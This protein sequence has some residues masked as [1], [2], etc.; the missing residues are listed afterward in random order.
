MDLTDRMLDH[1]L[2]L[3]HR[4]LDAAAA[5]PDATLDEP[6]PVT[7]DAPYAFDDGAPTARSMFVRLI[8]SKEVWSAALAGRE[9]PAREG[10]SI[11]CLRRR[12]DDAG[13]EFAQ[14]VR[15]IRDRGAWDAAFVDAL[16]DPPESFTYGGMV[17]H[18]LTWSAHR[19]H[20]L[21]GA[22]RALGAPE[23]GSGDPLEWERSSLAE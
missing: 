8:F 1:D 15:E 16:C 23:V 11:D 10:T 2:W 4:L 9:H 5:L 3:T 22:L 12:L 18:V 17:A 21:I 20:V 13:T 6:V 19:R 14:R 7:P